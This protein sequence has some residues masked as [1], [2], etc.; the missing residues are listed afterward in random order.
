MEAR[1]HGSLG[2]EGSVDRGLLKRLGAFLF[3]VGGVAPMGESWEEP[4]VL[5]SRPVLTS[6]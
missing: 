4:P 3:S 2:L 6:F 1:F 5:L